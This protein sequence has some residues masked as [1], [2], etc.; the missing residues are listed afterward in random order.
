M[1]V[2]LRVIDMIASGVGLDV[3][4]ILFV[5][6]AVKMSHYFIWQTAYLPELTY[7]TN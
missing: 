2:T 5:N 7:C 1:Q 6:S 4:H 3:G